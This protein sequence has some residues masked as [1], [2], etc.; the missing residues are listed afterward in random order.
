MLSRMGNRKIQGEILQN[1]ALWGIFGPKGGEGKW[2]MEKT[3]RG[4][5]LFALLTKYCSGNKIKKND[6]DKVCGTYGRRDRCVEGFGW[7]DLRKRD[8]LEN[9]GVDG[10]IILKYIFKKWNG[11]MD[12]IYLG[13]D[14]DRWRALVNAVMNLR[15]PKMRAIS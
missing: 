7:G 15:I 1:M 4:A 8:Y 9:L 3:Q 2:G 6:M 5:I 12:W 13:Q 11:G 10:R 14:S